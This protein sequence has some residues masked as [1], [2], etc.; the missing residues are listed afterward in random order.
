MESSDSLPII[1]N[2]K[3]LIIRPK[4][5][6]CNQLLAISKGIIF[7]IIS[8][9][10]IFFSG[11]QMDYRDENN[12]CEFH[13]V[14][15]INHLQEKLIE[16]NIFVKIFSDKNITGIK[17]KTYTQEVNSKIINFI[18]YLF[19]DENIK[20]DL[21]DID[22]PISS[23]IPNKYIN[24]INYINLN[25]KFTKKYIK[26]ANNI[27]NILNLENYY[28]IHIRLEDDAINHIKVSTINKKDDFEYINNI[29]KDMY[30]SELNNLIQNN[31]DNKKI[32]VCTSLG[33]EENENNIFYKE[34]KEKYNLIDKNDIIKSTKN[35]IEKVKYREIYGIIDFIIAQD[36]ILFTGVDWSSFSL[37]LYNNHI[38][39][40]KYTTLINIWDVCKKL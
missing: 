19:Y 9:R 29:C 3:Y 36:S 1:L 39:S 38:Y 27:K 35:L 17:I 12:I 10:D 11:F 40:N 26:S 8:S 25:I 7:G 18:D 23:N 22:N 2:K 4:Y 14:I 16:K 31:I 21:L 6:L 13:D 30:I 32:Y 5:G 24:L 15:D 33:Y 28:T 20:I 34:I 37:Y